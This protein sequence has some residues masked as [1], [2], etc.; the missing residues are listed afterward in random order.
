MVD[1]N[2][3][4][5]VLTS[6]AT[7][8]DAQRGAIADHMVR[9]AQHQTRVPDQSG[10]LVATDAELQEA[11]ATLAKVIGEGVASSPQYKLKKLGG[12][13][14]FGAEE[15]GPGA[16]EGADALAKRTATLMVSEKK[17]EE[18]KKIEEGKA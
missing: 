5:V 11:R 7:L 9:V 1:D 13:K 18:Q 12:A 2:A 4:R 6:S 16:M 3:Y 17:A 14:T 8:E 10:A 15:R